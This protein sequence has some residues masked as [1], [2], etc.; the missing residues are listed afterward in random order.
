MPGVQLLPSPRVNPYAYDNSKALMSMMDIMGKAEVGRRRDIMTKN[1][2]EALAR[3]EGREGISQAALMEPGF[4]GGIPGVLQ[5]IASPFA[6]MAPGI[7]DIIAGRGIESAMRDPLEFEA[8]R[9][10]IDFKKART[11][12]YGEGKSRHGVAPWWTDPE[13]ADTPEGR[14]AGEKAMGGMTRE[15]RIKILQTG[16]N[17]AAGQY[18]YQEGLEGGAE[19]PKNPVLYDYYADLL[20]AEGI[21]VKERPGRQTNTGNLPKVGPQ[22]GPQIALEGKKYKFTATNPTTGE[23]IGSNDGVKWEPIQ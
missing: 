7:D 21:P 23:K 19:Q 3:G 6:Q 12:Y 9:A 1:I 14:A 22:V 2:L 13:W 4:S 11:R 10:D 8:L 18:F 5:K 20:R 15:E 17:A 16:M